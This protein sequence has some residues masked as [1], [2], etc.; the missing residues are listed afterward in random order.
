MAFLTASKLYERVREKVD[1]QLQLI[2]DHLTKLLEESHGEDDEGGD[3]Y[4]Q[5]SQNERERAVRIST[6]RT[7]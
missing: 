3:E 5:L 6:T 1:K 4:K 2:R 7:R